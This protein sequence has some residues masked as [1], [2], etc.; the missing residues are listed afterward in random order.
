MNKM[1]PE[2]VVLPPDPSR[3]VEGLRDTGYDFETALADLID[4]SVDAGANQILINIKLEADGE[5]MISIADNGCGMDYETLLKGMTY[6]APVQSAAE[7]LGKFGLGLKTASTAFARQLSVVTRNS[8]EANI[9]KAVWDLDHVAKS[10]TWELLTPQAEPFEVELLNEAAPKSSG[11]VIIWQKIDR[12]LKSGTVMTMGAKRSA[13]NKISKEL[14]QHIAMV[15]QRFLDIND[16]R[17]RYIKMQL[18]GE[19]IEPWNPFCESESETIL[20]AN[21]NVKAQVDE[22][23]DASFTVR[24]F[25]IPRREQFSTAQAAANAQVQNNMQ[26]IY[27][28]RE[29]RLIHPA[30]WL[31]MYSKEPHSTLLR[32][33]FSFNHDLDAAFQVDIKKSKILLNDDLYNYVKDRILP[34]PRNAANER[35]RT[36]Q[37]KKAASNITDAHHSSNRTIEEN[38]ANVTNSEIQIVDAESSQVNVT[39]KF[40]TTQIRLK[41]QTSANKNEVYIKPEESLDYN[42]LWQPGLINGHPA[43]LINKSHPYYSKVYIP[44]LSSDVTIQ[45]LDSLLWALVEA[46]YSTINSATRRHFEE[47]R[48]EVSRILNSLVENFPEPNLEKE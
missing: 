1:K 37:R 14:R 39:N 34:A 32:V 12:V 19:F 47:L 40:G 46:E 31:G 22:E 6:G 25:V 43:V 42:A 11:T 27:I 33:E 4:N 5:I 28:Y 9:Q 38:E 13:L 44:N 17:A 35:Y 29:N 8:A 41:I 36:G 45:G 18:N 26:G 2:S 20:V 23:N 10:C 16:Q 7:R 48:Y 21:E 30:D 15:Y 24:A 3:L